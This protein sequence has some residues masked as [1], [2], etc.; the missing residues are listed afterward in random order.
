MAL[1]EAS[2]V[3]NLQNY[4]QKVAKDAKTQPLMSAEPR[5]PVSLRATV[6]G[7]ATWPQGEW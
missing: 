3:L 7:K 2:P 4:L 6:Q 5:E 1:A